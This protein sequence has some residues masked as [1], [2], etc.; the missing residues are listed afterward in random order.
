MD[1]FDNASSR[2]LMRVAPELLRLD[3]QALMK[4]LTSGSNCA[5]DIYSLG[6]VLWEMTSGCVPYKELETPADIV[7]KVFFGGRPDIEPD[8]CPPEWSELIVRCWAQEPADRPSASELVSLLEDINRKVKS[9]PAP[10][11][12]LAKK[13]AVQPS[14]AEQDRL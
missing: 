5:A 14:K 11:E 6:I 10:T 9:N 8:H 1:R 3:D 12:S 7:Q 2:D 4:H 13:Q